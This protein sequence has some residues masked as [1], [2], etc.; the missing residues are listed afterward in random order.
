MSTLISRKEHGIL[1]IC[2]ENILILKTKRIS[3]NHHVSFLLSWLKKSYS[4]ARLIVEN[5]IFVFII[6]CAVHEKQNKGMKRTEKKRKCSGV[7]WSVAISEHLNCERK[8]NEWVWD[9]MS[10]CEI[11]WVWV[12]G[13]VVNWS[14]SYH[15]I[16]CYLISSNLMHSKEK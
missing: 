11:V 5:F 6:T 10:V 13:S 9:S 1:G 2:R 15:L 8:N 12:D 4:I 16:S 14:T 7:E 3:E